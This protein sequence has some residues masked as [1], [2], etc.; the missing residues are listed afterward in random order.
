MIRKNS[1]TSLAA[2][3]KRSVCTVRKKDL[4]DEIPNLGSANPGGLDR[5]ASE[6]LAE[7]GFG[8]TTR[9]AVPL[10]GSAAEDTGPAPMILQMEVRTAPAD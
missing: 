9:G 8:E 3:V 7:A 10:G 5:W 2:M 6:L 1:E 4:T